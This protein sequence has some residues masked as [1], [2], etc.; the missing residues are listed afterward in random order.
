MFSPADSHTWYMSSGSHTGEEIASDE[1][2]GHRQ[3]SHQGSPTPAHRSC[4]QMAEL[5][6]TWEQASPSLTGKSTREQQNRVGPSESEPLETDQNRG[7]FLLPLPSRDKTQT[8]NSQ[9][10]IL[11]PAVNLPIIPHAFTALRRTWLAFDFHVNQCLALL[12]NSLFHGPS[13][14]SQACVT[15]ASPSDQSVW[16]RA[17]PEAMALPACSAKTKRASLLSSHA[18]TQT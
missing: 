2:E 13:L 15:L 3:G 16:E 8:S 12:E 6:T 7:C 10:Q 4:L 18:L 5:R 14:G 11:E 17:P 9:R 1:S